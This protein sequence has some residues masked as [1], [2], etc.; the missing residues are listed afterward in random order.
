MYYLNKFIGGLVSPIGITL[1]LL[2]MAFMLALVP[3]QK[4]RAGAKGFAIAGGMGLWLWST[5]LMTSI[6]GATLEDDF[7]VAGRVPDAATYPQAD[8]ILLLGGS[9]SVDTNLSASAEMWWSAD[10]VWMAAR[11]WKA[12][13]APKIIATGGQV[14]ASTGGLL[15]DFGV[16]RD[17]IVFLDQPRN[18]EEEAKL[19]AEKV[20]SEGEGRGEEPKVLLVTSAWHMRRARLMFETYAPGIDVTP[21]PADFENTQQL[22]ALSAWQYL[23]PQP[24]CLMMNTA[25]FREW[26]GYWGYKLFR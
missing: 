14:E 18:T 17:A 3:R 22:A 24:Q 11:L 5:P 19:I 21:A 15:A 13:K 16:P 12:G 26:L 9:M 10:R 8:A 20:R 2:A 7:L 23:V 6:V 25:S 4:F 1:V